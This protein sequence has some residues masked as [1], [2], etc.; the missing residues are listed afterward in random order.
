MR[1]RTVARTASRRERFPVYQNTAGLSMPCRENAHPRFR[2]KQTRK[3]LRLAPAHAEGDLSPVTRQGEALT[4]AFPGPAT[5][6]AR[7]NQSKPR[8]RATRRGSLVA[9]AI[10]RTSREDAVSIQAPATLHRPL[11]ATPAHRSTRADRM[12]GTGALRPKE[13]CGPLSERHTSHR[14]RHATPPRDG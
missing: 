3:S 5:V 6:T 11:P 10:C 9:I 2:K 8:K 1:R 12:G 13:P 4:A 7:R 14:R